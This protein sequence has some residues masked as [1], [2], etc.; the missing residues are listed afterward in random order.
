MQVEFLKQLISK[1]KDL[2][3]KDVEITELKRCLREARESL[4]AEKQKSDS[5]VIDLASEKVKTETAEEARKVSLAALKVAQENYAEVQLTVEPLI[6]DLGWMQLIIANSILNAT[7][8]D[9]AVDA[10]TKAARAVGHLAGYFECAGHVEE[11]LHQHFGTL[12]CS[13]GKGAKEGLVKA[14]EPYENLS[15]PVMDLVTDA[16]KHDDCVAQLRSIF[17]PPETVQLSDEEEETGDDGAEWRLRIACRFLFTYALMPCIFCIYNLAWFYEW[18]KLFL[19]V[20]SNYN[21]CMC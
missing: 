9:R 1:D 14:E 7:E 20:L 3:G 2:A 15:L 13:V 5:M 10:P 8:L 4:E 19:S 18:N 12:H 17:K 16:L 11:A 6:S 21:Y